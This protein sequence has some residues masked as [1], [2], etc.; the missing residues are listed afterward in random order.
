MST[1]ILRRSLIFYQYKLVCFC[2]ASLSTG[3]RC[4]HVAKISLSR[5]GEVC[6]LY[7]GMNYELCDH[8]GS[9]RTSFQIICQRL[10]WV[11][12]KSNQVF[13]QLHHNWVMLNKAFEC[14]SCLPQL[15]SLN[16]L[17]QGHPTYH[18]WP[19]LI[20]MHAFFLNC[21]ILA[22]M[23]GPLLSHHTMLSGKFWKL[24]VLFR[25]LIVQELSN[26][27]T[28]GK[29]KTLRASLQKLE[30]SVGDVTNVWEIL[31]ISWSLWFCHKVLHHTRCICTRLCGSYL[32]KSASRLFHTS[33]NS[34]SKDSLAC[35]YQFLIIPSVCDLIFCTV[36]LQR[37]I[38]GGWLRVVTSCLKILPNWL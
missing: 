30:T 1:T 12:S 37:E 4:N 24:F 17:F 35:Q 8:S 25:Y 27:Y 33:H 22:K 36:F 7:S 23:G 3:H 15:T 29:K 10:V 14:L 38:S 5:H 26:T 18:M 19:N 20:W 32:A 11:W 9:L 34:D 16:S 13:L 21:L 31:R 6:T 2:L 28:L